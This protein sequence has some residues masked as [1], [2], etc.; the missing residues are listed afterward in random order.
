MS[1][2]LHPR[3]ASYSSGA[4]HS[5][6]IINMSLFARASFLP[7]AC[8]PRRVGLLATSVPPNRHLRNTTATHTAIHPMRSQQHK[9]T[10]ARTQSNRN[11]GSFRLRRQSFVVVTHGCFVWMDGLIGTYCN[12]VYDGRCSPPRMGNKKRN[13]KKAGSW[14]AEMN[15]YAWNE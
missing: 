4:P 11:G 12:I 10:H 2:C 7:F 6:S 5:S 13:I 8:I 14:G 15:E 9:S 3:N 1:V